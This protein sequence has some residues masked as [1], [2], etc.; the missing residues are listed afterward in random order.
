MGLCGDNVLIQ[1]DHRLHSIH[2]HGSNQSKKIVHRDILCYSGLSI[3]FQNIGASFPS[4][5]LRKN[6][7]RSLHASAPEVSCQ[8]GRRPR[9]L[10]PA[11]TS[12]RDQSSTVPSLPAKET[13]KQVM[14]HHLGLGL[15]PCLGLMTK[16]FHTCPS[17]AFILFKVFSRPYSLPA[18]SPTS[19]TS[20]AKFNSPASNILAQ[21]SL[22][23]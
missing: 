9:T 14:I 12:P 2:F 17:A 4:S 20:L 23:N 21:Q 6:R 18:R 15:D 3:S 11:C 22:K 16:H 13:N 10:D 1:Q 19:A 7:P 8:F 5:Q